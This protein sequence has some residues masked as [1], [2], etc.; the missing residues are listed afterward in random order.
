VI[1][2]L[3]VGG[4]AHAMIARA[5]PEKRGEPAQEVRE[6][7]AALE[8]LHAI[9]YHNFMDLETFAVFKKKAESL[10]EFLAR[11]VEERIKQA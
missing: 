1:L 6:G 3:A 2:R 9:F 4:I 7:T 5:E 8:A 10:L 11:E